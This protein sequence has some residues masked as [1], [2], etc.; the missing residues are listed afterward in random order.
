MLVV[1]ILDAYSPKEGDRFIVLKNDGPDAVQGTFAGL[2]EGASLPGFPHLRITY[3]GGDGNDVELAYSNELPAAHDDDYIIAEDFELSVPAPGVLANDTD[4]EADDLTATLVMGPSHGTL[5]F[6]SNGSFSYT[7]DANY[8]GPDSFSY[9][10][11]DGTPNSTYALV[12][13][14][15]TG[16]NDP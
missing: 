10:V 4:V 7:P 8:D 11:S 3:A 9:S 12:A 2:P 1:N 16:V 13:L 15:M 14:T 6:N 5:D